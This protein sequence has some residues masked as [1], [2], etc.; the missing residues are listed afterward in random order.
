MGMTREICQK[1]GIYRAAST[2]EEKW[3]NKG[4]KFPPDNRGRETSWQFVRPTHSS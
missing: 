2:G 1:S 3:V 4:L